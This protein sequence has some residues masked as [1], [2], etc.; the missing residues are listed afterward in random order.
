MHALFH[1]TTNPCLAGLVERPTAR[2]GAGGDGAQQPQQQPPVRA[3][4]LPALA[5]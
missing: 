2:H 5:C 4:S 1:P 3:Y